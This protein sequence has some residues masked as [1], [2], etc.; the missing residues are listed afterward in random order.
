[1]RAL[2][3]AAIGLK[4]DYQEAYYNRGVAFHSKADN[5]RAVADFTQAISGSRDGTLRF[6]RLPPRQK[7]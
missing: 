5:E 7:T 2:R 3:Y 4:P 6:W 1:M